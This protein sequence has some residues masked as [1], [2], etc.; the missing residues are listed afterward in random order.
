MIRDPFAFIPGGKI[1][2]IGG[3]YA[4][5]DGVVSK[6]CSNTS[7]YVVISGNVSVREASVDDT[8]RIIA[9]VYKNKKCIRLGSTTG[10]CINVRLDNVETRLNHEKLSNMAG[11]AQTTKIPKCNEARRNEAGRT[12]KRDHQPSEREVDDSTN[13]AWNLRN[14]IRAMLLDGI[15]SKETLLEMAL[16]IMEELT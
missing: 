15:V 4:G 10:G 11:Q 13:V 5:F 6:R 16:A 2:V 12:T 8:D 14:V 1:E 7:S 9:G 3:K